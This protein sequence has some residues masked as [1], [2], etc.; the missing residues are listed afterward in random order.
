MRPCLKSTPS[1]EL[2]PH[3][4][5]LR[6]SPW[7][8]ACCWL[9]DHACS[10]FLMWLK[11]LLRASFLCL[12][13][14]I[15]F[16]PDFVKNVRD[17]V[18]QF[19]HVSGIRHSLL[20]DCVHRRIMHHIY[21]MMTVWWVSFK[22]IKCMFHGLNLASFFT[23]SFPCIGSWCAGGVQGRR[24][25]LEDMGFVIGLCLAMQRSCRRTV[26]GLPCFGMRNCLL[27]PI[28]S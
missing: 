10:I 23:P 17:D 16:V 8:D 4:N 12:C 19:V 21:K 25:V 22:R 6:L 15:N 13:F 7:L 5:A 2:H 1:V 27:K 3:L 11:W 26:H 18:S 20:F 14:I 28:Q 24:E 9:W